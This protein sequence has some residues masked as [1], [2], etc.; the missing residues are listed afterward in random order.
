M[1]TNTLSNL[2]Q[3]CLASEKGIHKSKERAMG[4]I[5]CVVK[6]IKDYQMDMQLVIEM[7][8]L[9]ILGM[10]LGCTKLN[11]TILRQIAYIKSRNSEVCH[12]SSKN[13][14]MIDMLSRQRYEGKRDIMSKAQYVKFAFVQNNIC[15]PTLE[16]ECEC[17]SNILEFFSIFRF[18]YLIINS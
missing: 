6:K 2:S 13:N 3:R 9:P 4:H 1:V 18:I 17:Y 8:S 14:A 16:N 7:N 10:T 11:L 12:I 5:G 15:F